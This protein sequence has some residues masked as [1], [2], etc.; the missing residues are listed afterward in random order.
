VAITGASGAMYGT[1]FLANLHATGHMETHVVISNAR[2][3]SAHD[4]LRLK[5]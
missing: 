3:L 2:A 4:E 5:R 1:R